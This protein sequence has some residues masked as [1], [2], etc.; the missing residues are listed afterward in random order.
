VTPIPRRVLAESE[1]HHGPEFVLGQPIH[2]F[3]PLVFSRLF[4]LVSLRAVA[5]T[6]FCLG[7]GASAD[8]HLLCM[9]VGARSGAELKGSVEHL[10]VLSPMLI[11]EGGAGSPVFGNFCLR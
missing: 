11:S 3:S 7:G 6:R 8:Q 9:E 4:T 5:K 1:F 10:N 2:P